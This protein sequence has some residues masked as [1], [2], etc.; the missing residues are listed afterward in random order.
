M[1][2]AI[3]FPLV[4]NAALLLALVFIYDAIPWFKQ[5]QFLG[6]WRGAL[7]LVIG[8]IGLTI[9]SLPYEFSEGI[10]FDTRGVLLSISGLYFG[11]IPTMVA[12]AMT[13]A[14]R[15][16]IGGQAMFAGMLGIAL[17]GGIGIMLRYWFRD[18]LA[19]IKGWQLLL[20]GFLVHLVMLFCML[21]MPLKVALA[22]LDAIFW[23]VVIICPPLTLLLGLMLSRR[24]W[25]ER[26]D[27]IK[28]QDD[29]LFRSQFNVGNIGI[30]ITSVDKRWI[31]VNPRLCQMLKYTEK[32][33]LGL[34]WEHMSHADDLERD[35]AFFTR[36]LAGEI[37]Q[38]EINKRFYAKDGSL[39][40]THMTVACKRSSGKVQ[41]VIAGFMDISDQ[42]MSELR[43][44]AS[45]EQ[46]SLVLASAELGF[47]D[48]DLKSDIVV[49]NERCAQML[50]VSMTEM[51]DNNRIWVDSVH[52]DDRLKLLRSLDL[53]LNG[54][55]ANHHLEYRICAKDGQTRWIRD[56]G[57]VMLRDEN[58][59][60]LRMCGIHMDITD[61]RRNQ[62]QLE[63]AASVYNTSTEAMSV[64]D[65]K[66]NII[67]INAAF[68]EITGYSEDEVLGQSITLFH[69]ERNPEH[70]FREMNLA[71][72]T[73]GRWQGEMWQQRKNGDEYLVWLTVNT[74]Y[75][76]HRR[77]YRRVA[78][79][80]D[81]TEKKAQEQLIWQQA[82]Y[83]PLTGLP[84]RRMLLDYLDKEI[85][86]AERQQ[87]HFALMFLDL[88]F[89][90]EVNDTLGHDMGDKLLVECAGR[91]RACVR[92]S[93]VVARLGGDEFT[94]M[95]RDIHDPQGVERVASK[96][97][98]SV[99]EPFL[100]GQDTAYISVSIGITLFP[101]DASSREALLKHADQ[102]MY[103]AK[104]QGRNRF[105]YFTPSMQEYAR[106]RM[107]LIQDLRLAV[108]KQQFSL[109]FQPIVHM[110]SGEVHKA[111]ALLRWHHSERG[112]VSPAEFIPVAED[113]GLI[114]EI[115]TWV[116][117]N[118]ARQSRDWQRKYGKPIQLSVNK[119]PVQFRDEGENFERWVGLLKELDLTAGGICI[120]ITEGLLLDASSGVSEKLLAYRDAGIQVSL[121]DF[122]TGYSSLAYLKKFDIDYL[123]I[124]QSFTRNL[125]HD[126]SDHTLCEA[127]IVMAHKLG[128]QVIA[129][130]VETAGQRDLLLAMGCDYGQGY[131]YSKPLSAADFEGQYLAGTDVA[132]QQVKNQDIRD[133]DVRE[134]ESLTDTEAVTDNWL[135]A[136]TKGTE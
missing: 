102:A 112:F 58:G 98:K 61:A 120:E 70:F 109:N 9:M 93:D 116:F 131:L 65:D 125:E 5:Q 6:L 74:I 27:K 99:A 21:L 107:R 89:F 29:F 95:I 71:L 105:N 7:G 44:R 48:W 47:W 87:T 119:S 40:H 118:A 46:L 94:V 25:L 124:D 23:P 15:Y 53:H 42:T 54:H 62:E 136:G 49:R 128:M 91:I 69:Y 72:I 122:G 108:E 126:S 35:L 33:L 114:L 135:A 113:T 129:E 121:D 50:G 111:E 88:D 106:Y 39:V 82:N 115:G 59:K 60:A 14:Y 130:G 68:C 19:D 64:M 85:A 37:D 16:S 8:L 117:E 90:K 79:F 127:I 80:S 38:Y 97:L 103:A 55:T 134:T 41:L 133:H 75:D 84:N 24:L 31:K 67:T 77:P 63:L 110:A 73:T 3:L 2:Q 34:S 81:I 76:S 36:M 83:D 32:E 43:L 104:E 101:D 51:M 57:R 11:A 123:K 100:L 52:T 20:M 13:A 78:L 26:D 96:I 30:A 132:G 18:K 66:G 86:L 28:L 4:V 56:T 92:E 22:F 45:R 17:S 12:A 10:Y 1:D